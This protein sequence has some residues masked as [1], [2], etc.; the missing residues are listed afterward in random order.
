M[1][2]VPAEDPSL[3]A[4]FVEAASQQGRVS[5]LYRT[6]A[7]SPAMLAAWTGMA[8]PLRHQPKVERRLRELGI[9]RVAQRAGAVYEWAHHWNLALQAGVSEEHLRVLRDWRTSSLFDERE[10]AILAYADAI[11]D[12]DVPD[13]VF[14]PLRQW[15]DDGQLVELTLTLSFYCHVARALIALRVEL[16]P[17]FDPHLEAL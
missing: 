9:M 1:V 17:G 8:W 11:C 3:Q 16:E 2:P 7:N 5:N 13:A 4:L 6:L 14:D 15:F 12:I 10:R